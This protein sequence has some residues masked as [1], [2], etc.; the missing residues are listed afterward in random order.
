MKRK[1]P[2]GFSLVEMAIVLVVA[3]IVLAITAPALHRY[4]ESYRVSDAARQ[5]SNELRVA[6][7]KAVT[8]G[9]RQWFAA[10]TGVNAG[11]YFTRTSVQTAPATWTTPSWTSWSMPQNTKL[12]APG[13][14]GSTSFYFDPNGQP[15]TSV[16]LTSRTPISGSVR[17]GSISTAVTDTTQVNL[18]LTGQV[19]Q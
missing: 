5:V 12:I 9:T 1:H 17:V 13:F 15:Y 19:W 18:D 7:Q 4:L 11:L 2:S 6:R 8:N 10:G 14:G 3:G 16:V